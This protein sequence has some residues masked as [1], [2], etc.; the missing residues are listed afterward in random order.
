MYTGKWM[1]SLTTNTA[2][3]RPRASEMIADPRLA[4]LNAMQW[5]LQEERDLTPFADAVRSA[6]DDQI[7]AARPQMFQALEMVC[8]A[9]STRH[10]QHSYHDEG[11]L[12]DRRTADDVLRAILTM[13][14][15]EGQG[16]FQRAEREP[17]RTGTLDMASAALR[18]AAEAKIVLRALAEAGV[19]Q[20]REWA[21]TADT[22]F[23]DFA[24]RAERLRG[25]VGTLHAEVVLRH[26]PSPEDA[27]ADA[28]RSIGS[29]LSANPGNLTPRAVGKGIGISGDHEPGRRML[30]RRHGQ[31]D[32]T[33]LKPAEAGRLRAVTVDVLVEYDRVFHQPGFVNLFRQAAVMARWYATSTVDRETVADVAA[34][35][36][37][38]QEEARR[39][40]QR[41]IGRASEY[42]ERRAKAP[43]EEFEAQISARQRRSL[44]DARTA[45]ALADS[46]DSFLARA[47]KATGV[48]PG[49]RTLRAERD[50]GA[51]ILRFTDE[52]PGDRVMLVYL[53]DRVGLSYPDAVFATAVSAARIE[54]GVPDLEEV[55]D[56]EWAIGTN[57]RNAEDLLVSLGAREMQDY[58]FGCQVTL[59][60]PE[61]VLPEVVSRPGISP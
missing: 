4:E 48:T 54:G 8:E 56:A 19:P 2:F 35:A 55:R 5:I 30:A 51:A 42:A 53:D 11:L 26:V 28:L 12:K 41:Q 17:G 43:L 33:P 20:G 46:V 36:I 50:G 23:S 7:E 14:R 39:A 32:F 31:G 22:L 25:G 29:A 1:G 52:R 18:V 40:V 44:A 9:M 61:E 10:F 57:F 45:A 27:L 49:T 13:T 58:V 3:G 38:D 24:A 15:V 59:E 60:N 37:G 16:H 34:K 6:P 21:Q 47:A